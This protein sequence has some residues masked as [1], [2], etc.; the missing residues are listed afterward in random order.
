MSDKE[1][2]SRS[3]ELIALGELKAQN[4]LTYDLLQEIREE[5]KDRATKEEVQVLRKEFEDYKVEINLVIQPLKEQQAISTHD[6][7]RAKFL[8][9]NSD[10]II[11]WSLLI[12]NVLTLWL[13]WK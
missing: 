3:M 2:S 6:K 5:L 13:H 9:V 12:A 8:F 7:E 4:K 10:K 1:V 11:L